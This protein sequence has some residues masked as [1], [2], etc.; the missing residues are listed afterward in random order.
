MSHICTIFSIKSDVTQYLVSK[1]MSYNITKSDVTHLYF[2]AVG[3]QLEN[4][5]ILALK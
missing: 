1:V 4:H 5:Y 2:L 3:C